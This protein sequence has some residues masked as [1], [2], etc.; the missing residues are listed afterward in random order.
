MAAPTSLIP[1]ERRLRAPAATH[2]R[3]PKTGA[4]AAHAEAIGQLAHPSGA[5]QA[6][7]TT[8]GSP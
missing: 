7:R 2:T 5:C 1:P 3:W 4:S 8:S 6:A